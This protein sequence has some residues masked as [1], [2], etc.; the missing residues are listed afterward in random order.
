MRHKLNLNDR[1]FDSIINKAKRVEIRCSSDR[2]NYDK[3]N[4][5]DLIEFKNTKA[6]EIV[7][8]IKEINHYDTAEELF[9]LEGT[10]YTTSSTNDFNEAVKRING[11][12]NYK[13]KISKSGVYAIH[14]EFLYS[15]NNIWNEL[16]NRCEKVIN[17]KDNLNKK[18]IAMLTE[19]G[20][21]YTG[22]TINIEN[23]LNLSAEEN[24]IANLINNNDEKI[25]K[26]VCMKN[27]NVILPDKNSLNLLV[28][29]SKYNKNTQIFTDFDSNKTVTI[30]EIISN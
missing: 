25:D 2:H 24:I 14:I 21:I 13:E 17:E 8:R 28:K 5:G 26:I 27:G 30:E 20:T 11:L 7:C 9:M 22:L 23:L 1:A 6:E 16:V 10:R 4:I 29:L 3:F 18:V 12:S 19:S 15:K